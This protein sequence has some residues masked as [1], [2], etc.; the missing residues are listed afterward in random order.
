MQA[1]RGKVSDGFGQREPVVQHSKL[2]EF[3]GEATPSG[4]E[5]LTFRTV[6]SILRDEIQSPISPKSWTTLE[7]W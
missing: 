1:Q 5:I 4:D 7:I 3:A 6:D 2:P